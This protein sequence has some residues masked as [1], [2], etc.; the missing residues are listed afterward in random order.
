MRSS[1]ALAAIASYA[2]AQQV[3]YYTQEF[4]APLSLGEC[5]HAT[6]CVT[7]TKSVTMDANWRWTHKVNDYANCYSGTSWDTSVCTDGEACAKNCALDGIDQNALQGTYG[8]TST[9]SEL[10]MTLVTNGQYSKNVGGRMYM[11]QDANNYEMFK[12]KGKE[13][14]FDVDVSQLP[15]GVNGALYFV[16]MSQNGDQYQGS[17]TAGAKY[18]TGYC[19]AQCPH[20]VKFMNGKANIEDWNSTTAMG[21]NGS[22]CAE[23]DIWEANSMSTSYTLHPC[24]VEGQHTCSSALECGDNDLRYDGVCDKDGC[25]FNPYRAGQTNFYG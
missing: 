25:D 13:F 11:M 21:K 12:L 18:G 1:F 10:K 5:T 23:M 16:E 17:N 4:H 3:G 24:N 19:D 20:D 7:Q 8:I 9:G 22:C 14:T 6:G 15:C 2:S